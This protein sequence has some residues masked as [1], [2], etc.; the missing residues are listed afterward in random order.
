MSNRA[1]QIVLL[2]RNGY[3]GRVLQEAL[4]PSKWNVIGASRKEC[5]LLDLSG[6]QR[7]F[8][9]I[10]AGYQ[11]VMTS[12]I[13]RWVD[14]SVDAMTKN[15]AMIH[16]LCG[17]MN[18]NPPASLVFLSTVDVYGVSPELPV[19]EGTALRPASYY[20][21]AKLVG[22]QLLSLW[23]RSDI[24]I[25]VFR[26]PGIYG[27]DPTEPSI[28]GKFLKK[29]IRREPITIF[30]NGSI[31]RDFVEVTDV[32]RFVSQVLEC[33]RAGTYNIAKGH[34]DSLL[35]IIRQLS[36]IVGSEARIQ[37]G[38]HNHRSAGSLTFDTRKLKEAF[39]GIPF[40]SLDEGASA[41]ATRILE[42]VQCPARS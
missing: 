14:D 15:I 32:C 8:R 18:D 19:N 2:G 1:G 28:V 26:L 16:N 9:L 7:F 35:E 20:A 42:T 13:N 27:S 11:L 36:E 38:P 6:C 22:E 40:K 31:L 10:P 25:T 37:F 33:P 4:A 23:N 29:L 24:P 5:D 17:S 39:P 3:I 21:I 34:S 12:V 30:G 41:F